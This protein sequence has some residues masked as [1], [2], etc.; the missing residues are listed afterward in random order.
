MP[1]QKSGVPFFLFDETSGDIVGVKDAD[2]SESLFPWRSPGEAGQAWEMTRR[3]DITA[4][5]VIVARATQSNTRTVL[6]VCPNGTAAADADEGITWLDVCDSDVNAPGFEGPTGQVAAARVGIGSDFVEFG[7]HAYGGVTLKKIVWSFLSSTDGSTRRDRMELLPAGDL[8]LGG[9]ATTYANMVSLTL[10]G[11]DA[12]AGNYQIRSAAGALEGYWFAYVGGMSLMADNGGAG[13]LD[14]GTAG[15]GSVNFLTGWTARW[16]ING[17]GHLVPNGAMNIGSDTARVATV[18]ATTVVNK[19][20]APTS[21]AAA[22]TLTAAEILVGIVQYTGALANLTLPTGASIDAAI[23]LAVD[24]SFDVVVLNTGSGV[25]TL[26]TNTNLT[27]VGAMTVANG[28]SQR[29]R[30]R[31]TAAATYSVYRA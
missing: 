9:P 6:D 5:P 8:G 3:P 30:F 25:A 17:S 27:L 31:K 1:Y 19:Q 2:G 10:G 15:S 20:A 11:N 13:N 29:F 23:A 24:D 21:K 22:A 26:L 28:A 4:F 14:V 18:Y 7:S 16:S 12:K